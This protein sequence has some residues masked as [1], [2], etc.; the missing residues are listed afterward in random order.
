MEYDIVPLKVAKWMENF[1]V[2]DCILPPNVELKRE[3]DD[4]GYTV[5]KLK[6][7]IVFKRLDE[8]KHSNVVFKEGMFTKS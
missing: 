6:G 8:G 3:I 5:Y 7:E 4:L 1:V 2:N